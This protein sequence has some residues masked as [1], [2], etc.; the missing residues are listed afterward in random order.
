MKQLYINRFLTFLVVFFQCSVIAL[1]QTQPAPQSLPYLQNFD[2]LVHSST[3]YPDGFQGWTA[4]TSNP[5]GAT[6]YKTNGTLVADRN[7]TANSTAA[8]NNGNFHNYNGKMGFLNTSALD[9]TIGFGFTTTGKS[10]IIVEYDAMV[11]R[12]SQDGVDNTRIN[13]M[14]LQYRVG[15]SV[16][17]TTLAST[18]YANGNINQATGVT[19]QNPQRIRVVLPAE[20]NNQSVV[21]IRWISKQN[22]GKGARPSFAIDNVNIQDDTTAPINEAGFPK[23]ENV[24]ATGFD[25][26]T[27][28]N[29][30]GKTYY[31]LLANGS[32]KPSV[33]QI[34]AGLDANGNAA[35]QADVVT[36][37]NASITYTK[38]ITGL[39]AN[40]SYTIYAVAEDAN[41]NSQADSN[42]LNVTTASAP[43]PLITTTTNAL[44]F[45]L[46]EQNFDT[47]SL[48]YQIQASNLTSNVTLLATGSFS[49]SKEANA[50]FQTSLTFDIA[51][52]ASNASPTVYVRFTPNATGALS[53]A[54]T[55]QSVG[56]TDKTVTLSGIGI[57]PYSQNFNDA[58]VLSN[59]GWTEYSVTGNT[60]KWASTTS[61]FNS[62]PAAI[63]INGYNET[64]ASKDWLISPRL[65]LDSFSNFPI[66]SFYSRKFFQGT[67]L[68][69]MVSVNYD[70]VSNPETATW[71]PLDG[72]FATTTGTFKL[73][74]NI[75]LEAYKSNNTYLA[76]VYETTSNVSGESAEWTLDDINITDETSFIATIS[77][78]NFDETAVNATSAS[79]SFIFK[80]GG[81]GNVTLTAPTDFELSI[82]N[83][84]FQSSVIVSQTEA[85][86]G[87]VVYA[88]FKPTTKSLNITETITVTAT[89]LKQQTGKLSGSSWSKTETFDIVSYNIEFFGTDVKG[90]DNKEFGP[91]DDALQIDNVAKVMNKLDADVYVV[92]EV[93]DE[94]SLDILIQKLNINGKIFDKVISPTWSY[95]FD[96]PEP[97]FPPQKLVVIYNT[98][99]TKV[100]KTRVMFQGLYDNIRAGKTMLTNYPGGSSSSFFASGR[101][102]FMVEI[103]TTIAGVKKKMNIIN[104]HARANSGTD[105]SKY[106]MRKY[107][108]E[109]LKDSLDVHYPNADFMIL[110][111]YNDDVDTSVIDGNPSSYQ[112]M[113]EDTDKYNTLTLD[114]SKA[115]AFT[116]PGF[117]SF[118]DHIIASN[119]WNDEYIL[120]SAAVYDPRAD[121]NNYGNT[122]SDHFPVIARFELKKL[123]QTITFDAISSKTNGDAPF[124][125]TVS[126]S[127]SLPILL[128]SSDESIVKIIDGK[129]TILKDG[130]ATIT[131]SQSGNDF[132]LAAQNVSQSITIS[133]SLSTND[134]NL[135]PK[136][137]V[138]TYPNPTNDLVNV[139]M[140]NIDNQDLKLNIYTINGQ[141]IKAPM[142]SDKNSMQLSVSHLESGVYLYTLS[143]DSKI[144]F[145]SKLIKK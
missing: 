77:D 48:N 9:L 115:G 143:K 85:I 113:V 116:S 124:D 140:Q 24:L 22:S 14:S 42:Q 30:V 139:S 54:I 112:K 75:N 40:T 21:Q 50:N 52:F 55:H 89:G 45:G 26:S 64:G 46:M 96:A 59:S 20:C 81:Y 6:S 67:T 11:I 10:G 98:Q 38:S 109:L 90:S 61:R 102:P 33:A 17:F 93:S 120:N 57:N 79:K 110:G 114:I 66:L 12:N 73:S 3:T 4:G 41:G 87:K 134:L 126:T 2:A 119:E 92:Q 135:N 49:I 36:I 106:N 43:V 95:S 144:I 69:L 125:A 31:V 5:A 137:A 78:L 111:D 19:P 130:T 129:I 53:G 127:S 62:S 145:K 34:K 138:I 58:N 65:R 27:K 103:E 84:T 35:L 71:T 94:P 101:L 8:T 82:D 63:Q 117:S 18:A 74:N 39:T 132:Y 83:S 28:I 108:A 76:W 1:A 104:I 72:D 123:A 97:N 13:E 68:K 70:G 56:A 136:V 131:A 47:N 86:A 25:F 99:N 29:E 107:D 51:N 118:L 16:T 60:V 88:R 15:T 141:L 7:L 142:E 44:N 121:I 37:A 133:P 91:T 100:N 128:S 32:A 105:I 23:T 80:A 122:T